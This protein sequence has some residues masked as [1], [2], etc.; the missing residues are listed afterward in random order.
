VP[1]ISLAGFENRTFDWLDL[2]T[3]ESIVS[4]LPSGWFSLS[5][6]PRFSKRTVTPFVTHQ[7]LITPILNPRTQKHCSANLMHHNEIKKKKKKITFLLAFFFLKT[8]KKKKK[9]I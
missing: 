2:K 4:V 8:K 5:G 1:E 7:F 3:L 6:W 9:K